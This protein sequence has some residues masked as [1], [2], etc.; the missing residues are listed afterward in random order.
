MTE[1]YLLQRHGDDGQFKRIVSL[2]LGKDSTIQVENPPLPF[3]HMPPL[4]EDWVRVERMK[5]KAR[6]NGGP[7]KWKNADKFPLEK[8]PRG[9]SRSTDTPEY[10]RQ[11]SDLNNRVDK[12]AQE[13][14]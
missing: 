13:D 11:Q 8:E 2:G 3:P 5:L 1:I 7:R 9:H 4:E 6:R 12:G 10:P 14:L